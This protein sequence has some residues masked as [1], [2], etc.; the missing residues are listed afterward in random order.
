MVCV[1]PSAPAAVFMK[2]IVTTGMRVLKAGIFQWALWSMTAAGQLPYIL[3]NGY[4]GGSGRDTIQAITVD[5]H[6]YLYIAGTT[7]GQ[8][9]AWW[10]GAWNPKGGED[11]FVA[12][13]SPD[14]RK[15]IYSTLLAGDGDDS[16]RAVAVTT[17]G[18]V[19]V[20]GVTLSSN[21]PT[22]ADAIR[23]TPAGM[24]DV[25]LA[26]LDPSG[27]VAYSTYFGGSTTDQAFGVAVD[28]NGSAYVVGQTMSADFPVS[29]GAPQRSFGGLADG[30]VARVT[31]EGRLEYSTFAGGTG[32]EVCNAVRVSSDR[33]AWVAGATASPAWPSASDSVSGMR[34]GLDAMLLAVNS[35]GTG[36]SH[37]AVFGDRGQEQ[38]NAMERLS[39]GS[40]LLA[41]GTTSTTWPPPST[42]QQLTGSSYDAVACRYVPG[43]GI[44]WCARLGGSQEEAATAVWQD[45][46]SRV[47]VAGY[48]G[49]S[50]L[51]TFSPK[52]PSFGGQTDGFIA[53]LRAGDRR[54]EA[55][56]YVGGAGAERILG[57]AGRD[58]RFWTAGW[59]SMGN[60][61]VTPNALSQAFGG[62]IDGILT[63]ST[64]ST[65]PEV[66]SITPSSGSGSIASVELVI[67]DA[68]GASDLSYVNINFSN[69]LSGNSACW[70]TWF[71]GARALALASNEG[72]SYVGAIKEGDA[73]NIENSQC[74]IQGMR[75]SSRTLGSELI[76]SA[77]FEFSSSFAF[78]GAGGNKKITV[79][80]V[81]NGGQAQGDIQVGEWTIVAQNLPPAASLTVPAA[82]S[83]SGSSAT[84]EFEITDPNGSADVFYFNVLVAASLQPA[85]AC[86]MTYFANANVLALANDAGNSYLGVVAPGSSSVI[87]NSQC[88]VNGS[89][90]SV[91]RTATSIRLRVGLTFLPGFGAPA[92]GSVKGI[93]CAP[94]DVSGATTGWITVGSWSLG[95]PNTAPQL[96]ASSPASGTGSVQ[97]FSV[98]YSDAQGASDISLVQLNISNP[99][100]TDKSCWVAWFRDGNLL[101]LINDRGDGYVGVAPLGQPGLLSNSQ[102]SIDLR[103]ASLT[104]A[105]NQLILTT[106]IRFTYSFATLGMG[107]AK[108]LSVSAT[109]Q[110]GL[111]SSWQEIG[112]W[113]VPSGNAAPKIVSVTPDQVTGQAKIIQVNV[114]DLNGGS[115]IFF[116]DFKVSPPSSPGSPCWVTYFAHANVLAL[117]NDQSNAY[118]GA[119]TP[120]TATTIQNSRCVL[121]GVGS[122]STVVDGNL[123]FSLDLRLLPAMAPL[124][125]SM[126]L[127]VYVQDSQGLTSGPLQ[128]GVWQF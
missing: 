95:S 2:E 20:A 13:L 121:N 25:F 87:S 17:D 75:L 106:Q 3:S 22:T 21:F 35:E 57:G 109:D 58:R 55:S 103:Q 127:L 11:T 74:R 56:T 85:Q 15:V 1:G 73:S 50:D 46:D 88:R 23:R 113:T 122:T 110:G 102:C 99:V 16:A 9:P 72:N 48:T 14:G 62:Q 101:G 89:M 107:A 12:K 91:T 6:G 112:T 67:S 59:A 5:T 111:T 100:T 98:T 82:G 24:E 8:A 27:A 68:N 10:Q 124:G 47:W 53:V 40:I 83:G 76:L 61:L 77:A 4:V 31:M 26:R 37:R 120:G 104:P 128:K 115:D 116:I 29:S 80:A 97:T 60:Q 41:G 81:D 32:I 49:S 19:W 92:Q 39:D 79:S 7:E 66:V 69:P 123:S 84:L 44:S 18:Q 71:N 36:W 94:V 33:I 52:Q 45:S 34:G 126:Q 96:S 86:W 30:F 51:P 42:A 38:W 119:I 64:L 54:W 43:S 114:S 70:S 117:A 93:Y 118:V 65:S 90:V 63:A 125:T 78:L 108:K 105:G 28:A